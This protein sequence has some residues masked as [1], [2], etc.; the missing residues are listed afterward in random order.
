ML[1][2]SLDTICRTA[3]ISPVVKLYFAFELIM[4]H[5]N[6]TLLLW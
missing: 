2:N 1:Q 4:Y 6:V 5:K 3:V